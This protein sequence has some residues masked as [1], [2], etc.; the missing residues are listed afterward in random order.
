MCGAVPAT[1]PTCPNVDAIAVS[2][3]SAALGAEVHKYAIAVSDAAAAFGAG[4]LEAG[5]PLCRSRDTFEPRR[6]RNQFGGFGRSGW[7]L[8]FWAQAI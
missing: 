4:M 2:A 6:G 8:N 1:E 7:L 3:P 5:L